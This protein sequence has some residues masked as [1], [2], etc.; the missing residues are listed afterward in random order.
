MPRLFTGVEIPA[1][2][3]ERLARLRDGLPGA[4]WVEPEDYHLTLRF[5]G[6]VGRQ[7]ANEIHF[8]LSRLAGR[9][10]EIA[11]TEPAAFGGAR[12]SALV[13]R[14]RL[15]RDLLDLQAHQERLMRRLGLKPETRKFTPHVTLARLADVDPV[16]VA[17]WIGAAAAPADLRFRPR[18]FALYS[19]ADSR[20]GGPYRVEDVFPLDGGF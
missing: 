15:D 9:G 1:D 19:S 7:L 8:E 5:V 6:D 3:G 14:A 10:G 13:F 4:R 12:P 2:V 17:G 18:R 20:G 11:L 16:T